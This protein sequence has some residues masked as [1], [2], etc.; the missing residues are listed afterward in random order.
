MGTSFFED[1]EP[2]EEGKRKHKI[3]AH[4]GPKEFVGVAQSE[5]VESVSRP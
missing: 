1:G 3:I 2:D 5:H 4:F